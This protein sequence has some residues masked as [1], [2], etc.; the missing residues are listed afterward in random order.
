MLF[1]VITFSRVCVHYRWADG[2]AKRFG[3]IY[4]DFADPD[5]TRYLKDSAHWYAKYIHT[6]QTAAQWPPASAALNTGGAPLSGL[7]VSSDG[8]GV[9]G[10]TYVQNRLD[11]GVSLIGSGLYSSAAVLCL[12]FLITFVMRLGRK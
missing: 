9:Y 6:A 1:Y 11:T 10:S 7:M 8:E 2:Y 3:I 12:L 4:V 5:R